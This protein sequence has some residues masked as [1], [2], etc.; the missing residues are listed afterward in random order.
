MPR[1]ILISLT[2]YGL[3]HPIREISMCPATT[4]YIVYNILDANK[5]ALIIPM[6]EHWISLET[7]H[8]I[9]EW[10]GKNLK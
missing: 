4:S 5:K 1:T 2:Y 7:G 8:S 3:P 10:I 6:N 9:M